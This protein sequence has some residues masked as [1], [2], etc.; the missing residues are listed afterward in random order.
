MTIAEKRSKATRYEQPGG[1]KAE[2][3][4]VEDLLTEARTLHVTT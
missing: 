2:A 1:R 3:G 4:K